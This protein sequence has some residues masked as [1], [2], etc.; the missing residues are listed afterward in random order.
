MVL[1]GLTPREEKVLRKRFGLGERKACTLQELAR[2]F[3]VTRERIRQ[4]QARGMEKVKESTSG[5]K[6]DLSGE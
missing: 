6:A 1:A 4:I 5:R 3:G 2:E